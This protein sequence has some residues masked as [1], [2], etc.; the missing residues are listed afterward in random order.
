M[1]SSTLRYLYSRTFLSL[2]LRAAG[3]GMMFFAMIVLA[4]ILP[5]QDFGLYTYALDSV[6]LA[7]AAVGLGLNQTAVRVVPDALN[8]KHPQSLRNFA[9]IGFAATAVSCLTLWPLLEVARRAELLPDAIDTSFLTIAILTLF[10]IGS[11]RLAQEMLRG[12]KLIGLSQI[13]EQ[14]L[15]P[16]L[17]LIF[18]GGILSG[19]MA[20]RA[21]GILVFQ[22]I[23]FLIA[24]ALLLAV[25]F[26]KAKP[27]QP[28]STGGNGLAKDARQWL[29]IGLPLAFAGMLSVFL[30]RGDML[31]L[32]AVVSAAELAPYAASTR[33]AGLL[34]FALGAAN[35]ATAPLMRQFWSAGD[36]EQLQNV[37]DRSAAL[38]LGLASPL[39]IIIILFPEF[40]LLAF[41]P[42]FVEGAAAL[43]ILA[44]GQLVN[45]M[46][47][48]VGPLMIAVGKQGTYAR[49]VAAT[50]LLCAVLLFLLV[51]EYGLV[52]AAIATAASAIALNAA[53][54]FFLKRNYQ[55]VSYAR[56]AAIGRV[57]TE[58][59][60]QLP[61]FV[62]RKS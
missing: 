45:A 11:L 39:A 36:R 33:V 42:G 5:Q 24:T 48:P 53:L 57:A 56:P 8:T 23:A 49:F 55:L 61:G 27:Q 17:L 14:I 35:A 50:A 47:G 4:R 44:V 34:I 25:F 21:A 54:A 19:W 7:S 13:F 6:A 12:A 15:W 59:A 30:K 2:A 31:A 51:P 10:A 43:R 16:A 29:G 18:A 9:L 40:I 22:A 28:P 41:G 60:S 52:G 37:A 1:T 26:G 38:A 46:T 20:P 58:I 3:V 32:G 62:K